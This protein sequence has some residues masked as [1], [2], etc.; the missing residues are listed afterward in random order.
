MVLFLQLFLT[1]K[2]DGNEC[3]YVPLRY[4]RRKA[5]YTFVDYLKMLLVPHYLASND[6]VVLSWNE[7]ASEK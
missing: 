7:F 4:I 6:W 3:L 1:L 5:L 2:L